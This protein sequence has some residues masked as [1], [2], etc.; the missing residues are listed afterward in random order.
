MQRATAPRPERTEAGAPAALREGQF[1]AP[2][3]EVLAA[4]AV[5][6]AEGLSEAEAERRRSRW[7]ANE[8]PAPA[9]RG[10]WPILLDQLRS[11]MVVLLGAAA[12][13]SLA[14]GDGLDAA[15]ILAIVALNTALGAV[16]EL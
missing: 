10:V 7:G 11:V 9:A 1:C 2:V 13:I 12:A 4:L 15:A 8:L 16:Q 5:D 3:A 6:P 14:L